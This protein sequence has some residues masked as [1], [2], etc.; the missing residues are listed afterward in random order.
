RRE[1]SIKYFS[2][3][4]TNPQFSNIYSHGLTTLTTQLKEL[5]LLGDLSTLYRATDH[6]RQTFLHMFQE[7]NNGLSEISEELDVWIRRLDR[8]LI[9]DCCENVLSVMDP[10]PK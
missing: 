6:R 1:R 10:N 5:L 2:R 8:S 7:K 3:T 9:Q 4:V